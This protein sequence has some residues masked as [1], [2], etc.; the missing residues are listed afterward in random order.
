MNCELQYGCKVV[1]STRLLPFT[2]S[3]LPSPRLHSASPEFKERLRKR[4]AASEAFYDF[5]GPEEA[6][7][8]RCWTVI[9]TLSLIMSL[10]TVAACS[11]VVAC[12]CICDVFAK[13][14]VAP[15]LF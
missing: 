5:I 15:L 8:G 13:R 6:L 10:Q 3:R 2:L 1:S 4:E 11:F 12:V 7:L 9:C 14:L